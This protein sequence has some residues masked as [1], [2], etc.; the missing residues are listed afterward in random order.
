M[1]RVWSVGRAAWL[2]RR[3]CPLLAVFATA[4]L[5]GALGFYLYQFRGQ[6]PESRCKDTGAKSAKSRGAANLTKKNY[7]FCLRGV[8]T[9][10]VGIFGLLRRRWLRPP[11]APR[12]HAR[13]TQKPR[14]PRNQ[15]RPKTPFLAP[16]AHFRGLG[17]TSPRRAKRKPPT[18]FCGAALTSG[19]ALKF[20]CNQKT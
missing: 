4:P 20:R 1:F 8:Y 18:R 11:R 10:A 15:I 16:L 7:L 13:R 9:F 12:A 2:L 6:I 17:G 14:L 19:A 5:G 3:P